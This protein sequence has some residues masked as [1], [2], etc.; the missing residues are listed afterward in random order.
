MTASDPLEDRARLVLSKAI[1]AVVDLGTIVNLFPQASEPSFAL[2]YFRVVPKCSSPYNM[3]GMW[4]G[5]S[6]LAPESL[7]VSQAYVVLRSRGEFCPLFASYW[8]KTPRVVKKFQD[9]DGLTKDR[10]HLF[11]KDFSSI[12]LP[13]PPLELQRK[14][15][16]ALSVCDRELDCLRQKVDL[17]KQQKKGLLQRLLAG[18]IR[19][20]LP[21]GAK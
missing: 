5:G 21:K 9:S 12:T 2:I 3:M 16:E 20:E 14:I 6:G 13:V 19:I 10:L 17:L 11:F 7:V 4:Q 15:A 8:F 1:S 18:K